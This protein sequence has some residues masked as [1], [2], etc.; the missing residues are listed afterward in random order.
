MRVKKAIKRI[1]A[2]GV[3]A[4][5]LGATV[6][7]AMAACDLSMYPEPFVVDGTFDGL[8]V[9]GDSSTAADTLGVADVFGS[10]QF[11]NK[12]A[13]GDLVGASV[14]IS[15]GYKVERAGDNFN[16]WD[17]VQDI[18]DT[19]LDDAELPKVLK[20]GT[21]DDSEGKTDNEETYTQQLTFYDATTR[22]IYDKDD[23]GDELAGPYLRLDK[24]ED[25][26]EYELE[27]DDPIE[28]DDDTTYSLADDLESTKLEIMGQIY[29]ITDADFTAGEVLDKLTLLAGETVVWLTE[30]DKITKMLNGVEHEIFVVDVSENEDACGVSVDGQVVWIDA[31]KTET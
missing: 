3:G 27:F 9:V 6:L 21:Y 12:I 24:G 25:I 19:A 31:D 16:L 18:K 17:D 4:T 26:Y 10:L 14:A 5:M 29:T 13:T 23:D 11:A 15:E 1:V 22:Y 20:E 8:L 30:G 2:L 7:G 28:F